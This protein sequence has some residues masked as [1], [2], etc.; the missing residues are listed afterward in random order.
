MSS[1][2]D[3]VVTDLGFDVSKALVLPV[4]IEV[5]GHELVECEGNLLVPQGSLDLLGVG[6]AVDPV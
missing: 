4:A 2:P 5:V 6:A 3:V 1:L